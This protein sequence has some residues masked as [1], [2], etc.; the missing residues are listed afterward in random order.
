MELHCLHVC[1]CVFVFVCVFVC[2]FVYVCVC[3]CVC[4][5]GIVIH[6]NDHFVSQQMVKMEPSR[7]GPKLEC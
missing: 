7:Y 6:Y 5:Y 1:V 3:V 4:I 2:V